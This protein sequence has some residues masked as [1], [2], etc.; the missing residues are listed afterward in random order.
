MDTKGKIR[1]TIKAW[2]YMTAAHEPLTLLRSGA[3]HG[4]ADRIEWLLID[5]EKSGEL[6]E[7]N[8]VGSSALDR[9]WWRVISA[10][11]LTDAMTNDSEHGEGL[12]KRLELYRE[13]LEDAIRGT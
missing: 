10:S 2:G 11:L 1:A 4:F 6:G 9:D 8:Y 7:M 3:A 12:I 13:G 5:L